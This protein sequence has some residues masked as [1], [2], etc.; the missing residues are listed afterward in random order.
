MIPSPFGKLLKRGGK[1]ERKRGKREE[2]K[3]KWTKMVW[4]GRKMEMESKKK[5]LV[6]KIW[7][8]F[9]IG[10]EKVFKIDGTVC[11]DIPMKIIF[12]V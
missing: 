11:S 10:L 3:R 12:F 9:Q 5:Y 2:K 7:K 4:M 6:V 8:D 1:K